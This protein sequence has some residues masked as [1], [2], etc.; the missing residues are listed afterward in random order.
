MPAPKNNT[1]AKG[2]KGG[3]PRMYS[4]KELSKLG[5]ELLVW[6]NL[7]WD[8]LLKEKSKDKKMPFF[9]SN[10]C[11]EYDLSIDTL[12]RYAKDNKEFCGQFGRAKQIVKDML[13]FGGLKSWWNPAAFAFVAKNTTDMKDK[14][15]I[16]ATVKDLTPDPETKKKADLAIS[17]Y[18]NNTK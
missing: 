14:Q 13:I 7:K 2:N 16:E 4:D 1:F 12:E 8:K 15:E 3:R 10:F 11:R 9:I 5:E 17:L 6:A 18:L